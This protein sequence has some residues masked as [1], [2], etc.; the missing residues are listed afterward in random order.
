MQKNSSEFNLSLVEKGKTN[1]GEGVTE[2][3]TVGGLLLLFLMFHKGAFL[4]LW[5]WEG[6]HWLLNYESEHCLGIAL[7]YK[8]GFFSSLGF[9]SHFL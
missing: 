9:S 6:G 3:G 1:G 7:Q 4:G 5:V 2:A 8:N